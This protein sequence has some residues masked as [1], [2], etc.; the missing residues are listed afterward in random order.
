[1][2][3]RLQHVY[4]GTD[5]QTWAEFVLTDLGLQ[6]HEVVSYDPGTGPFRNRRAIEHYFRLN[7]CRERAANVL[8]S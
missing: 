4:F 1:V 8:V 3:Q 5:H 2:V 7:E 6:R